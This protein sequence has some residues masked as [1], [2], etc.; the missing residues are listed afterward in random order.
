MRQCIGLVVKRDPRARAK[1]DDLR[2]R[3]SAG[4]VDTVMGD[5]LAAAMDTGTLT[6]ILVLGGDGTFL[7]AARLV[8]SRGIP[9]MGIKFG[10]VGFLAET[11]EDKLSPAVDALLK[12]NYFIEE[13]MR[14]AVTVQRGDTT[15]ASAD[16][17]NDVVLNKGALS[18][19][20]YCAVYINGN[21]LTTFKAD[22]LI[23]GTPTGST[24]YSLA[25]GGPVIHPAVPGIILTPICPF[26]LTNRPLIVPDASGIELQLEGDPTDIVLTFDGQEGMDIDS[27]DRIFVAKSPNPVRMIAFSEHSYYRVLKARLLWSGGR[28]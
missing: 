9:L 17:L 21:Y 8:G 4:G 3:L 10:E 18:R 24:A 16:V 12:G 22:G 23:V 1:A 13:R 19:L 14:L 2:L 7:S 27:R 15:I 20:A 6:C 11:V 28:S 25:A 5:E 26:T